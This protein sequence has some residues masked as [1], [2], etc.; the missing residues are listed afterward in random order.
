MLSTQL[1]LPLP[2][3]FASPPAIASGERQKARDILTAVR[4]LKRIE[5][6]R[7]P[8]APEEKQALARFGGFGPVALSIFPDP[9]T[10][11]YKDASWQTLGEE[12][13]TLLTPEEYASAKRTTYNAFYTSPTVIAAMHEAL[14]R[15]GV[16][17]SATVLEPGCGIGNFMAHAPTAMRFIGVERDNISGRIAQAL[18][19]Q[20]DIRIENFRDA[21]LPPL[22]AVIGNVP[23][24]DEKL[25]HRGQRFS[26][27][28]YFI[29]KSV[30]SLKPGGILAVVT[31]HFTLDKQ[32]AGVRQYL[33][34][35]ADF[36]G[37]IRLLSTAFKNEGTA[38]VTDV[39]FLR[40]AARARK[41]ITPI[42][43][44]NTSPPW[45]S[46]APASPSTA[47]S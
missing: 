24:A 16:P 44:G 46:K 47:I 25:E 8:A 17:P 32:N 23:F 14:A 31:S 39:V 11:R 45:R 42:P 20:A 28:D 5:Q 22:D 43:T 3:P 40:N 6:E 27:H 10:A 34:E 36:L 37:A 9:V 1:A 4:T 19:P 18:Y 7:R 38:V 35:R 15:L 30:D 33:A 2:A 12:L 29:A 21:R 13:K 41:P 26:I